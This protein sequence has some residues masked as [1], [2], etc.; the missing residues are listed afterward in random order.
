MPLPTQGPPLQPPSDSMKRGTAR[1]PSAPHPRPPPTRGSPG[2]VPDPPASQHAGRSSSADREHVT[3]ASFEGTNGSGNLPQSEA[4]L[5]A[6]GRSGETGLG[7]GW[8][9]HTSF[10]ER[11]LVGGPAHGSHRSPVPR[12]GVWEPGAELWGVPGPPRGSPFLCI[13]AR[14]SCPPGAVPPPAA[15]APASGAGSSRPTV[16][17]C[18]GPR[19]SA[20]ASSSARAAGP[21]APAG[22]DTA[23]SRGRG[24]DPQASVK[25]A[26][27][28]GGPSAVLCLQN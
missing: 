24:L 27:A 1:L 6:A 10:P 17:I 12:T 7:C 15:V 25:R 28:E 18:T 26:R 19:A 5:G 21:P 3:E 22:Q 14:R 9:V 8:L 16:R 4:P 13:A 20:S 23:E 2:Q 11:G